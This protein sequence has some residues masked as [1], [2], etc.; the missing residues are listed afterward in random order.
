MTADPVAE[1]RRNK[2]LAVL[3]ARLA[4]ME[5]Q[6]DDT[7]LDDSSGAPVAASATGST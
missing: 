6:K 4:A 2:A 1:R 3:D 7:W 5:Q